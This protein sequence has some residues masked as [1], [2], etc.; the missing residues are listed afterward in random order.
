[1]ILKSIDQRIFFLKKHAVQSS[2]RE[3][4]ESQL[5]DAT[6]TGDLAMLDSFQCPISILITDTEVSASF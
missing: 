2:R 3:T 4:Y 5:N 6:W 1:M